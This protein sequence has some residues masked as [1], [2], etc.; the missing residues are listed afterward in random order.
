MDDLR[1]ALAQRIKEMRAI[2]YGDDLATA[3]AACDVPELT[4]VNYESG[5]TIPG[6]VLLRFIEATGASPRWL[7]TGEGAARSEDDA[8]GG[9]RH[10]AGAASRDPARAHR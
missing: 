8:D 10:E 2:R 7:L 9:G 6:H 1:A 4:W 5:V 3:A